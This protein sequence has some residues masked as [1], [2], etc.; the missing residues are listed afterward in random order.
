M[1]S[2]KP[3]LRISLAVLSLLTVYA[4]SDIAPPETATKNVMQQLE[5][6]CTADATAAF[7]ARQTLEAWVYHSGIVE[8]APT[9]TELA[10]ALLVFLDSA[11]Q[12]METQS[13][14][15]KN[16]LRAQLED[17]CYWLGLVADAS[18]VDALAA[19]L[20]T[21]GCTNAIIAALQ[22]IPDAAATQA[23][24][25]ALSQVDE[26]ARIQ[27]VAALGAR[28]GDGAITA[29]AERI[30]TDTQAVGWACIDALAKQ[31]VSPLQVLSRKTEFTPEESRRF[32]HAGLLAAL[33]TAEQD[34][35]EQSIPALVSFTGEYAQQYQIRAALEALAR[36]KAPGQTQ[37]ALGRLNAPKL[38]AA[39]IHLLQATADEAMMQ[40]WSNSIAHL[41]PGVAAALLQIM[42]AHP[43]VDTRAA[44]E[45]ATTSSLPELR[46]TAAQCLHKTP[47]ATDLCALANHSA[48]YFQYPAWCA[49]I[50]LAQQAPP[51]TA[52][53]L[54]QAALNEAAPL[55]I[56]RAA[57]RA[58]ID[59]RRPEDRPFITAY[60]N[61]PLLGTLVKSDEKQSRHTSINPLQRGHS[62]N[63]YQRT[64]PLLEALECGLYSVEA[65]IHLVND[66]LLVAHD[67]K[68]CR[69]EN[70]LE[71]LYL[72]PLR[73]WANNHKGRI[74]PDGPPLILL[75][76]FKTPGDITYPKLQETLKNYADLLTE[77]TDATTHEKAITV[78]LSGDVPRTLLW[79]D[80]PRWAAVD[81]RLPDLD[82]TINVH[83]IPLISAAWRDAFRWLGMGDFNASERQKLNDLVQR[84]HEKGCKLRFWGLP[85]PA[86]MWPVLYESGVDLLNADRIDLLR[87][88]LLAQGTE[89]PQVPRGTPKRYDP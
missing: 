8:N 58:L 71:S 74:Y 64:R 53:E 62:H 83:R 39:A 14:P 77:F 63:D 78:I 59:L 20:N 18:H 67:R 34:N 88:F 42:S 19:H 33:V 89:N 66:Q 81:G 55:A 61:H 40:K 6:L 13:E 75:I 84:T 82:T 80:S 73:T 4:W 68:D 43:N 9:S 41:Q 52:A 17:V 54:L 2:I 85:F 26:S 29:L 69:P 32:A 87:D 1:V 46:F 51:E 60:R 79:A 57:L 10:D 11:K 48:P 23:L 45:T 70:T 49:C 27:I 72:E 86:R 7:K 35:A 24:I 47:A 12:R 31:G 36:L 37:R 38:R 65:D 15:K 28:G 3:M 25:N 50:M 16:A 30:Q 44:L 76:D 21:P 22:R 5:T 56:Q